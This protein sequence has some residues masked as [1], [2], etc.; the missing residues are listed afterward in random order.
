MFTAADSHDGRESNVSFSTHFSLCSAVQSRQLFALSV[1]DRAAGSSSVLP[2]CLLF[3]WELLRGNRPST[4]AGSGLPANLLDASGPVTPESRCRDLCV[5]PLSP[6][7][8]CRGIDLPSPVLS[9]PEPLE[10][11]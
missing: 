7:E 4:S 10:S 9:R 1:V 8:H 2:G 11:I 3:P 5:T 6:C